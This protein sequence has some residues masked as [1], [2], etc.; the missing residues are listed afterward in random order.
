MPDRLVDPV[1][2]ANTYGRGWSTVQDYERWRVWDSA[3]PDLGTQRAATVLGLPRGTLKSWGEGDEPHAITGLRRARERGWVYVPPETE[4]GQGL[5]GLLAWACAPGMVPG[6]DSEMTPLF[7]VTDQSE[8]RL[9]YWARL[10]DLDLQPSAKGE[11]SLGRWVRADADG[12]LLGRVLLA[13]GAPR[14]GVTEMVWPAAVDDRPGT[15]L[16]RRFAI[17]WVRNKARVADGVVHVRAGDAA[18]ELAS[19]L[20]RADMD[21]DREGP[22]VRC[23]VSAVRGL[24]QGCAVPPG[25]ERHW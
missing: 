6:G 19:A 1:A 8:P 17:V 18:G 25:P 16:E 9:Q 4:L 21:V 23:S 2:L 5:V 20:G 11:T 13:L 14:G 15:D 12:N 7:R 3:H 10:A 22:T 24:V